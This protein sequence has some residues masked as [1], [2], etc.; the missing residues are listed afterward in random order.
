MYAYLRLKRTKA[1]VTAVDLLGA[2]QAAAKALWPQVIDR[3]M[4]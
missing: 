2:Y 1:L 4:L 3:F